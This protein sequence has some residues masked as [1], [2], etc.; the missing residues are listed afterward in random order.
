[1]QDA[2]GRE[3]RYPSCLPWNVAPESV[4]CDPIATM[5]DQKQASIAPTDEKQN[6]V[7]SELESSGISSPAEYEDL[8]DPDVGKTDAER[9]ALVRPFPPPFS[10]FLLTPPRIKHS[11]GRSIS[12]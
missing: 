11:C 1:V 12:G 7:A 2:H 4:S 6:A 3:Y 8:P 5:A 9:A 10:T